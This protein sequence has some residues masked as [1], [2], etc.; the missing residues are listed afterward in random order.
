M[1]RGEIWVSTDSGYA[2]KPRP[3]VIIQSDRYQQNESVVTCLITSHPVDFTGDVYRMELPKTP[4]NGLAVDS[5]IMIDKIVA[6]PRKRLNT[7]VGTIDPAL[8]HELQQ[9]LFDF[10]SE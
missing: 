7:Y 1:N 3:V 6:I 9:R 4:N 2:T 5:F 8:M 10:I